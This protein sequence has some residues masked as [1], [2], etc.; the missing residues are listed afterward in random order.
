MVEALAV[1]REPDSYAD[2]ADTAAC[3]DEEFLLRY[4][5]G[6]VDPPLTEDDADRAQRG[7]ANLPAA[8][9]AVTGPALARRLASD[10][11]TSAARNIRDALHRSNRLASGTLVAL[12]LDIG[13]DMDPGTVRETLEIALR[14]DGAAPAQTMA[15]ALAL[16]R[17]E[18]RRTEAARVTAAAG[19]LRETPPG[20]QADMLWRELVAAEARLG[21]IDIAIAMLDTGRGTRTDVWQD[22]VT[23]VIA[24][25]V[26]Q[27]DGAS[28]LLLAHLFGPD[29]T[30]TGSQAGRVRTAAA[31]RLEASG[32]D[33]AAGLI[34]THGQRLIL[35]TTGE[36]G[37]NRD[38]PVELWAAGSWTEI[39]RRLDGPHAALA[40]RMARREVLP[41]Q[42]LPPDR[43]IDLDTLAAQ[44]T[45]SAS[46]RQTVNAVLE[47]RLGDPQP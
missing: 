46:L 10:G 4:V 24:D 31:R 17:A 9:Q 32:L 18:G 22:T 44:V 20:P 21:R 30:E 19:L 12:D 41:E 42:P 34:L 39:A 8:L 25:R 7:F 35:P 14:D 28:L 23:D 45:D 36:G 40:D 33:A 3:N 38:A 43:G 15:H 13:I 5:G 26:A 2:I 27:D 47:T 1:G 37:D 16:D 6:A 29:W 11:Q